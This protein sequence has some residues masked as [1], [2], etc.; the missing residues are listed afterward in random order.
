MTKTRGILPSHKNGIIYV[1]YARVLASDTRLSI[2][3]AENGL[4]KH[5]SIPH[6]NLLV[7]LLGPGTSLTQPAARLL[8]DS[9]A[10]VAFTAGGKTPLYLA[11][12]NEYRPTEY[13]QKWI[14]EW[15]EEGGRLRMAK[16]FQSIRVS[17]IRKY[18]GKSNQ[19]A[20]ADF[21]T[22]LD[23]YASATDACTSIEQL[24]G[25]EGDFVRS[26]YRYFAQKSATDFKRDQRD[27]S[28]INGNITHG[29]YLAYGLSGAVLW[30]L[31]IPYSFPLSHG[32]T[33]RGALVFDVADLIK[34]AVVLPIAFESGAA[35]VQDKEFRSK[36]IDRIDR[37]QVIPDLFQSI[38]DTLS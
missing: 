32:T 17:L 37:Y 30:V 12:Q 36:V 19:T 10:L 26:I 23:A 3:K 14:K 9:G 2:S 25:V 38:K 27:F 28:G 7:L 18:W 4:E 35:G 16:Q 5:V 29:N 31:G 24:L 6:L 8:A 34:D 22:R 20:L 15:L 13:S 33:R 21:N 1:E 11:S